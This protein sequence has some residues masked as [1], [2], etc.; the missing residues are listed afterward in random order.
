VT[1][2]EPGGVLRASVAARLVA[3]V[4]GLD[5]TAAQTI[6]GT[7]KVDR[8]RAMHE[9]DACLREHPGALTAAPAEYPLALVRLAHALIGAGYQT[10]AAPACAR[11]GKATIDLRRKTTSGRVCGACAARG[12][13]A[14]CARCG[15]SKRINARRPEGGICSA[16]YAKDE[17]VIEDCSGCGRRRR[18][19]ARMPDG[20]ARCQLCATRPA[21]TCS[22][23][24]PAAHRHQDH[25]DGPGLRIVLPGAAA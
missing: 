21:R 9:V 11:C 10:V 12:N 20:S 8:G 7:A 25:R 13:A 5:E 2:A 18:P 6:L 24:R 14:A 17:Q 16:C 1:A 22:R 23:L 15:Q 19:A 3:T 4:P